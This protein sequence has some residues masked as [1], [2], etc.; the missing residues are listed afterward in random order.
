MRRLAPS[1]EFRRAAQVAR[2]AGCRRR[3]KGS[4]LVEFALVLPI[5]LALLIGIMEFGWMVKNNLTIANAARE[6]VRN[7]SLGK[8]T[9]EIKTRV[10]NTATP[11]SVVSPNGSVTI[12]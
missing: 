1:Q 6:G 8:T 3:G 7:A 9:T 5:L 4:T 2:G 10:Q 12:M 11:L